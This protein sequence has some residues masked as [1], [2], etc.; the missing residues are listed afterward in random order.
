MEK[1]IS[2]VTIDMVPEAYKS[3]VEQMGLDNFLK[4]A[5]VAGGTTIYV[6]KLDNFLRQVRDE[7][8]R[9]EF[10]G[11]NHNKIA[12]KYDITARRVMEICKVEKMDGQLN[13][14]QT[15]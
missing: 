7:K 13:F 9:E 10:N 3:F 5:Q 14:Y 15:L 4:L 11:Y 1:W 6:P 8:I 12:L 2:E